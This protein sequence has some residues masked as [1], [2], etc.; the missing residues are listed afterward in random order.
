M[1]SVL[2]VEDDADLAELLAE[3]FV[4]VG[5]VVHSER[6]GNDALRSLNAARPDVIVTDCMMPQ[7]D[8]R[9]LIDRLRR[10][11]K[12]ADIPVIMMSGASSLREGLEASG[13]INLRKPF[14]PDALIELARQ[15]L[16]GPRNT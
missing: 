5:W 1:P 2:L 16:P 15:L 11:P 7:M 8:G 12:L 4:G 6:N 10:N 9:E 14:D 13:Q 3:L